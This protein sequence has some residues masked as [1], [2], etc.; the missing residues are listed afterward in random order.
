MIYFGFFVNPVRVMMNGNQNND[1]FSS[2]HMTWKSRVF[3]SIMMLCLAFVGLVLTDTKQDGSWEY[4][5]I[6]AVIYALLSLGLSMY[7]RKT[8]AKQFLLTIWHEVLHWSGLL[9]SVFIVSVMVQSGL[10]SRFLASIQML[11][12]LA[13]ATFLAGVY[14]E[15]MYL[16][17][18][19]LIGL[20]ALGLAFLQKYLFFLMLP[21]TIF[22]AVALV[23][24][25]KTKE[26]A[27]Q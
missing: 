6:V 21:L 9:F 7:V 13:L 1:L 15:K 11:N 23:W 18:G 12:L 5:R 17:V 3:V 8:S 27:K 24:W 19:I 14:I 22:F 2:H 16:F 26:H 10:V 25:I 20:F 4:W